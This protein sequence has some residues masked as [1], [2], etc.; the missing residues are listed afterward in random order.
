MSI[1]AFPPRG[2]RRGR[3]KRSPAGR[4]LVGTEH[5]PVPEHARRSGEALPRAPGP[6]RD[7]GGD[8]SSPARLGARPRPVG[9]GEEPGVAPEPVLLG[10]SGRWAA[11]TSSW[12]SRPR[13]M[14][15]AAPIS[16]AG[17]MPCLRWSSRRSR[18]SSQMRG[19]FL[20][21]AL[22]RLRDV[23][24]RPSR[25]GRTLR[26]VLA[27]DAAEAI[28]PSADRTASALESFRGWLEQRAKGGGRPPAASLS[29]GVGRASG[30]TPRRRMTRGSATVSVS[31]SASTASAG[32]RAPPLPSGPAAP[33]APDGVKTTGRG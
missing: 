17:W 5:R 16:C 8:R 20:R 31:S 24:P 33:G 14:R 15:S 23:R 2:A 4:M 19:P 29:T 18:P 28:G 10:R 13:S 11:R 22:E 30:P 32:R 9:A 7:A 6:H 12:S 3:T 27:G 26:P 21:V 1:Y 25:M